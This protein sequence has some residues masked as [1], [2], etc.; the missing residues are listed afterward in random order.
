MAVGASFHRGGAIVSDRLPN[1]IDRHVASRVR[2]RRLEAGLTQEM[3]ADG[4]SVTFQQFQKYE[5]AINRYPPV[6]CTSFRSR[7][8]CR[9]STSSRD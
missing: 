9:F 1:A 8:K 4:L 7:S 5:R 3:V 2:L 6:R